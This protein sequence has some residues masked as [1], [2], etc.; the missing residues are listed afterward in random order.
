MPDRHSGTGAPDLIFVPRSFLF[1]QGPQSYF[2]EHAGRALRAR[3][4][5]VHRVNLNLGDQLFWRLPAT[6]YRG[7][8]EQWPGFIAGLLEERRV[9]DLVL[10]GDRRPYHIA[11]AGAARERGIAVVVADL[12]YVRPDWLTLEADGMTTCSRFPRDPAAIRALAENFPEPDLTRRFHTPFW[13]LA[14][15][16]VSY[17]GAAV[18][19]RPLYP[20]YRRH[21]LHHP[22]A[23][24]AAWVWNA[25]RRLATRRAT[26]AAKA[27]LAAAPGD[28]FLYP[29]QLA[30]DFQLRAHSPFADARDALRTVLRSFA[31]SPGKTRLIIVGHPLDEGLIDW[32][33]LVR[34]AG[35]D[36]LIFLAGGVPDALLAGAAGMVTVNSTL[37]LAA[38]GRGVPVKTLGSAIY[39]VPGLTHRGDLDR[40]W[41]APRPPDPALADAFLRALVGATQVKGG[42]HTRDAREA[43]LPV[44]VERLEKGLYPLPPN[45]VVT[46]V[47]A[48]AL[49]LT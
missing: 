21:G 41:R 3:G 45:S 14:V 12:G 15:A 22:F 37:G 20:H 44:F 48:A 1:L 47:E 36:R 19:G 29:L 26:E 11:A 39:E 33:R 43:A 49:R 9:T 5:R 28:Y 8:F 38:L 30:S 35:D 42:W 23:E 17:H 6:E 24:Y 7:R 40:F 32:R 16:D 27:R 25:P 13:R 34:D 10:L 46:P 4:H 31:K 2:F 18:L